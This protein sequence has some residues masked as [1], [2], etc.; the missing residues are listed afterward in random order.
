MKISQ[1]DLENF[2]GFEKIEFEFHDKINL[3]VDINGSG[4]SSVLHAM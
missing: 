4:K 2:K 1:L 3:F